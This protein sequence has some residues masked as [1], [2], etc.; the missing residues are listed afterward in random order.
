MHSVAQAKTGTGKT[1]AFLIPVLQRI[2]ADKKLEHRPRG[3]FQRGE[4]EDI[5]AVIVSPTRELAEQIAVEA[6]K[7]TSGTNV[8]VQTAV[9]GTRKREGL[10]NIQR[11]GCH[12]LVGTPGR[13]ND[14]LS[15]PD[16]GVK[17]PN[18]EAF[19]LDEADRLLDQGFAP[20]IESMLSYLP[21]KRDHPHQTLMFSATMPRE[22]MNLVRH[23]LK[24]D[25]KF[26]QTIKK[27][28]E[29]THM[30]VPQKLVVLDGIQN[31]LPALLELAKNAVQKHQN[32]PTNARPFKA[33][34][35][36][37]STAE[38]SLAKATFEGLDDHMSNSRHLPGVR[39]VEMQ[40]RLSQD[41]RTRNSAFFRRAESAILF[42][43]DVTARGMDFPDVTHVIQMGVPRDGETYVHR[44]GRTA[45]AG[46]EGEGWLLLQPFEMRDMSSKL[47]GIRLTEDK[48]LSSAHTSMTQDGQLP[49]AV[50]K[51]FQAVTN[52]LRNA[53]RMLKSNAYKAYLGIF[54]NI[55]N[56]Q[57][58]IDRIHDL[59]KFGWGMPQP[60]PVTRS[61]VS[62]IGYAGVDG[63]NFDSDGG[64]GDRDDDFGGYGGRS[65]GGFGR[66]DRGSGGFGGSRGGSSG[67]GGRGRGGFDRGDR[68]SR[69]GFGGRE[70][71]GGR[72]GFGGRDRGG[73]GDRGFGGDRGDRGTRGGDRG[74]PRFFE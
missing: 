36:F 65:S 30:R 33:I 39:L 47:R 28:E 31:Q 63:F 54:A 40:S 8:I 53:P 35:Y 61:L 5:R 14:I 18:L 42:S 26:V 50:A 34:V 60:F 73:F 45:R 72:S 21:D 6:T 13:L 71:R 66:S 7:I 20:E 58:V 12:I 1:L 44:L 10:R 74:E 64:F 4:P 48:S 55:R 25:F 69:G 62:K 2:L 16:S 52:G 51:N 38:V 24:P 57:A 22:V 19:V 67:F 43:S 3:R 49:E 70:D 32:D 17:A 56:K 59:T 41:Q 46:K 68:G 15:D 9:G 11:Q 27:D 37:N 23:T 29:P